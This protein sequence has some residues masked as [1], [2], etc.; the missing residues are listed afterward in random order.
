MKPADPRRVRLALVEAL[1][2]QSPPAA[3]AAGAFAAIALFAGLQATR[4]PLGT[5]LGWAGAHLG[6]VLVWSAWSVAYRRRPPEQRDLLLW[7]KVMGT[8]FVLSG[9]MWGLGSVLFFDVSYPL[10][11]AFLMVFYAGI[12]VVCVAA[13]SANEWAFG[14]YTLGISAPLS[15][16][17]LTAGD[18]AYLMMGFGLVSYSVL[19]IF[20]SRQLNRVL[21][22]AAELR[23]HNED[24]VAAK[25]RFLAAASHDLRQPLHA[26]SLFVELLGDRVKED[27]Q[28]MFVE[29]IAASSRALT[30]LLN[31]LL[32]L[33]RIDSDAL[34]PQRTH[35]ALGPLFA[36]LE[37][38]TAGLAQRAGLQ[39]HVRPT[40]AWVET[41]FELLGR[42][43]RNLLSNALRYTKHGSVTLE[44]RVLPGRRVL[45]SVADTGPGIPPD[46][47]D[48]VFDEFIQLGNPERDR[49]KGL[50]LG[51]AIVRGICKALGAPL[52]LVS[53]P[54]REV[55]TELTVELPEGDPVV[56]RATPEPPAVVSTLAGRVVLV[57]DDEVEIRA[58]MAA[59]LESWQCTALCAGS[60][61][62]AGVALAKQGFPPDAVVCDWRLR[63]NATGGQ[64]LAQ[65]EAQVG[66]RL[67]A[68]F[69]T[70]DTSPERIREMKSA[71]HALLFKPVMPGKL[72]AALT[73][74]LAGR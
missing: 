10:G 63:E 56:A 62:E 42:V 52:T 21:R 70:G 59:L 2:V 15:V 13:F 46:A 33:S 20:A 47:Q 5:V 40:T 22:N 17:L 55:G 43:L 35:F 19:T 69:V 27:E 6:L 1:Y 67:P 49:E 28:R 30:G 44:A 3:V 32:D 51:L 37:H 25:T 73:A 29:R 65:L 24:L 61:A 9:A 26:L 23:F 71:G 18:P 72:R 38:E 31:A 68:V 58:G 50:G 14:L 57:I 16:K 64:A 11:V 4:Y 36:T 39:L 74:V 12:S 53:Q 41:D 34:K 45:V 7:E 66:A 54:S 8:A 48:R 60:A